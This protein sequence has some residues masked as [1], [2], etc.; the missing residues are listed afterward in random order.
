MKRRPVAMA[1]NIFEQ[2]HAARCLK[3]R[4]VVIDDDPTIVMALAAL[5]EL[6]GYACET[7]ASAEAYLQVLNYNR[8]SFSGPHCVLSDLMMPGMN[9]LELQARLAALGDTPLLLMSGGSGVNEA[10]SG[11][12]G[13]ALDFL[14]K[15]IEADTLL[16]A[17]AHALDVSRERQRV[18]QRK[19]EL[20]ARKDSLT[21]R[22][23]SVARLVAQGRI[24]A[25][26]AQ[27]MG[28]ALRT[29]KFHRQRVMEKLHAQTV[30]DLVRI[31][32]EAGL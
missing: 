7:H 24:N 1:L 26:I 18:Q 32:D 21:E 31:A 15:P 11:F 25:E 5:L 23:L 13:G 17:V 16:A 10:V 3:G 2:E 14:V 22:E 20:A 28:I 12:R 27:D 4:V 29:V 8:P 19:S 9:G 30:A 6:E